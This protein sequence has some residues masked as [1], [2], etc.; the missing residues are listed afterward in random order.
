MSHQCGFLIY[1]HSSWELAAEV[2]VFAQLSCKLTKVPLLQFVCCFLTHLSLYL[3]LSPAYTS[4]S[5][6]R[7]DWNVMYP[8]IAPYNKP[9]TLAST[10]SHYTTR[11]A[12][13]LSC[14]TTY[15]TKK[16]SKNCISKFCLMHFERLMYNIE[17]RCCLRNIWHLLSLRMAFTASHIQ[18]CTSPRATATQSVSISLPLESS[19]CWS[20]EGT[21]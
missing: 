16:S 11:Q 14:V 12:V 10:V 1:N 18:T 8:V 13:N 3:P 15:Q 6:L 2:L 17:I 20:R 4:G 7:W 5:Y 9:Q 21:N 19:W